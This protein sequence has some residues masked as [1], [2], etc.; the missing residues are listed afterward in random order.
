MFPFVNSGLVG[1]FEV[2]GGKVELNETD[3][4]T[5]R[6]QKSSLLFQEA[7][8]KPFLGHGF[9]AAR[10]YN[11][12]EGVQ[13]AHNDYAQFL[14]ESGIVGFFLY[15]GP[16]VYMFIKGLGARRRADKNSILCKIANFF[17]I[18]TPAFLLM[19]ASDNLANYIII[20][21]YYWVIAGIFISLSWHLRHDAQKP[22]VPVLAGAR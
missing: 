18:A 10:K 11:T 17:T 1:I 16:F 4:F 6:L 13:N 21:W 12:G 22:T 5:W 14:V 8:Q 20:Q 9:N 19:S 7:A 3:N 2:K 15:F